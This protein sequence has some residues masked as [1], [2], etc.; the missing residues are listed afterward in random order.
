V[1]GQYRWRLDGELRS[2]D[3]LTRWSDG[4]INR[5]D[6]LTRGVTP[7]E[8][9]IDLPGGGADEDNGRFRGSKPNQIL[10]RKD[11]LRIIIGC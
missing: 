10:C 5:I 9:E 4:W 11:K 7:G 2:A 8:V 3:T 1:G 6:R